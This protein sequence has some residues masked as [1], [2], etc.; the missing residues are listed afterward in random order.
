[1]LYYL[2]ILFISPW[3]FSIS[4]FFALTFMWIVD[5]VKK[6]YNPSDHS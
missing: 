2:A 6:P 3:C 4:P 1:M 5:K